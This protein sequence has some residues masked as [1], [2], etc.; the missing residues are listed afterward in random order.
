MNPSSKPSWKAARMNVDTFPVTI[1]FPDCPPCLSEPLYAAL[2]FDNLC[3]CCGEACGYDDV[4]WTF[5]VRYCPSC[6]DLRL[7]TA[8]DIGKDTYFSF[9]HWNACAHTVV[10]RSRRYET[11]YHR[12]EISHVESLLAETKNVEERQALTVELVQNLSDQRKHVEICENW[13]HRMSSECKQQRLNAVMSHLKKLGY[14][15]DI[16]YLNSMYKPL[17]THPLVCVREGLR[18]EGWEQIRPAIIEFMEERKV[19]RMGW[20]RVYALRDRLDVLDAALIKIRVKAAA[21]EVLPHSID[22]VA[23]PE[24]E[25]LLT[26]DKSLS[27][28]IFTDALKEVIPRWLRDVDKELAEHFKPAS[29][30]P[31]ND[32]HSRRK[33]GPATVELAR[34]VFKCSC[35]EIRFWPTV[36]CHKHHCEKERARDY[37]G[38]DVRSRTYTGKIYPVGM[39]L[40]DAAAGGRYFPIEPWK[41]DWFTL[42]DDQVKHVFKACGKDPATT[43]CDDMDRLDVRFSCKTCNKPGRSI[44]IMHWRTAIY[45][46]LTEHQYAS[47]AT[48]WEVVDAPQAAESKRLENARK[49]K[50]LQEYDAETLWQCARCLFGTRKTGMSDE[51]LSQSE[52][53]KHL[54]YHHRIR[55]QSAYEMIADR[56]RLSRL[57]PPVRLFS[58]KLS[59]RDLRPAEDD[60]LIDGRAAFFAFPAENAGTSRA[61]ATRTSSRTAAK[62]RRG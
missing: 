60:M 8:R 28:S 31:L 2:M 59:A 4:L 6:R 53:L 26:G 20:E 29:Y 19:N 23:Y 10:K 58:D 36:A 40:M 15:P 25:S 45:H 30:V 24:I 35:G 34:T 55:Q 47:S 37:Q 3:M 49:G 62:Q 43:T 21:T 7:A 52:M 50:L 51:S 61:T 57:T 17:S 42:C 18:N 22:V 44:G 33:S 54:R 13:F 56:D 11:V 1:P 16:R 32:E 14:E 39:P 48:A 12:P 5:F 46:C 27:E 38:P 9:A 41:P